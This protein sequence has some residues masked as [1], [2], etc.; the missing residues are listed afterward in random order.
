MKNDKSS[1]QRQNLRRRRAHLRNCTSERLHR[2]WL[3]AGIATGRE[4]VKVDVE[5][6][7]EE[8]IQCGGK[9]MGKEDYHKETVTERG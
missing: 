1:S 7:G 5:V 9:L 4:K 6:E 8:N 2:Q 3:T